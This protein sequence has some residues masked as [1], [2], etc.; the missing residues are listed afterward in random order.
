MARK[1]R[2]ALVCLLFATVTAGGFRLAANGT[3][4]GQQKTTRFGDPLPEG[5]IRQLA[6][7]RFGH[8]KPGLTSIATADG[9]K[10]LT[11]NYDGVFLWDIATGKLLKKITNRN[12]RV[13][14]LSQAGDLLAVG[15]WGGQ[16][17][18][19]E[20]GTGKERW[21]IELASNSIKSLAFSQ[22]GAMLASAM[23]GKPGV[24]LWH[25]ATGKT[26]GELQPHEKW[27]DGVAF[28]PNG[29]TIFSFGVDS[30]TGK[31]TRGLVPSCTIQEW[32]LATRKEIRRV[33][34]E[35]EWRVDALI[36]S[37]D[38]KTLAVATSQG[39]VLQNN[40]VV[41]FR[42][43]DSAT[44]Q[45]RFDVKLSGAN[46]ANEIALSPDGRYAAAALWWRDTNDPGALLW[47]LQTRKR[48]VLSPANNRTSRGVLFLGDGKTLVTTGI[49]TAVRLWNVADGVEHPLT[50][51][52]TGPVRLFA[53]SAAG[54][55]LAS[56]SEDG[57]LQL[58]D[59]DKGLPLQT[60]QVTA[61]LTS[62][63][64]FSPD[65]TR[66]L[67][68]ASENG[69]PRVS[70]VGHLWDARSGEHLHTLENVLH[71]AG[72]APDGK[73][74][75]TFD[76]ADARIRLWD[77]VK[78]TVLRQM[79]HSK[80]VKAVAFSPDGR[81][82]A[83]AGD[84]NTVRLWHPETGVALTSLI[85][86]EPRVDR[87]WFSPDSTMLFAHHGKFA[88]NV[89]PENYV[90]PGSIDVVETLTGKLAFSLDGTNVWEKPPGD[91]QR[92]SFPPGGSWL[93]HKGA[94]LVVV[95]APGKFRAIDLITGDPLGPDIVY[96][97]DFSRAEFSPD[98]KML[99]LG[100][101]DG[102]LLLW[103][104]PP[105]P[106]RKPLPAALDDA[107]LQALWQALADPDAKAA[108][109]A[110]WLLSAAPKQTLS[111]FQKELRPVT[112]DAKQVAGWI[113]QLDTTTFK[114]RDL[115]TRE[116]EK[117]GD[118]V[119][120]TLRKVL[121]QNPTLE[122]RQRVELILNKLTVPP[123]GEKLR[124]L[125]AIVILESIGTEDAQAILT[126]L[127]TSA[128]GSRVAEA[129]QAALKRASKL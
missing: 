107:K 87:V 83:S 69:N 92:E 51:G 45:E 68:T 28:H 3:T 63:L 103:N 62:S 17:T 21:T 95:S 22:D 43:L 60:L 112:V 118:A 12:A 23:E 125:R 11:R 106:P 124:T 100:H 18:V 93:T 105:L 67:A 91:L 82:L 73:T 90:K 49:D 85:M 97:G 86:I 78:G 99:A 70:H 6:A 108:Y 35:P 81:F 36:L 14:A 122:M 8:N 101:Q 10:L 113:A 56:S 110:R 32:D 102:R 5:A 30:T 116:L 71:P 19:F 38:G 109:Q 2:I 59:T 25:T 127:A 126:T 16:L 89:L 94:T 75:A 54:G 114:E 15:Q 37:T 27:V 117:L 24:N 57:W 52:P 41:R 46:K 96:G 31:A 121:E 129:A 44:F 64:L 111:L 42:L 72:F 128:P 115:A 88:T 4:E 39:D 47:D 58:W 123:T 104:P 1:L 7:P 26:A 33:A 120:G 79:S 34:V 40:S 9:T 77:T 48:I 119:E 55:L 50:S 20:F 98:G 53:L 74:L 84:D 80:S 13:L 29:K 61:R 76:L 65:G 66:L